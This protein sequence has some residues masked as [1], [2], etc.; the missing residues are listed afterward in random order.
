MGQKLVI[1]NSMQDANRIEQHMV[2]KNLYACFYVQIDQD[3][4][5][6]NVCS[7]M[8]SVYAPLKVERP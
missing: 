3:L 6:H 1:K 4:L 8:V 7:S 5:S 2:A